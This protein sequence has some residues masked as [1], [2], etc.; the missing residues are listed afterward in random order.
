[1]IK[2]LTGFGNVELNDESS[3][4]NIIIRTV[5]SRFLEIKFRG[6]DIDPKLEMEIRKRVRGTLIRGNVQIQI[7]NRKNG[8]KNGQLI[9]N[10]ERF[11]EIDKIINTAQ[12]EFG[13]HLDLSDLIT[14]NDLVVDSNSIEISGSK[15]LKSVNEAIKLVDEMRIAEGVLISKDIQNRIDIIQKS[16]DNLEKISKKYVNGQQEKYTD[17]IK[18]LLG[19]VKVDENRIAQEIAINIDR[20]DFTEEI[21]RGASHCKQ[22]NK[23]MQESEPVGKKLNFILQELGREVNTIGSKSPSSEISNITIEMKSEIE[24]VREQVQNIL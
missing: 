21:V 20:F 16:L 11:K 14:L 18:S 22:F 23:F 12:R 10:H 9:F 5:N 17:K 1:M 2:S 24:K 13:R 3:Q 7:F 6:I 4:I 19:D 8:N 15:L